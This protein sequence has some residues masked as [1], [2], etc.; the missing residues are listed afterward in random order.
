MGTKM[1]TKTGL[2][3]RAHSRIEFVMR[4]RFSARLRLDLIWTAATFR[5]GAAP[6]STACMAIGNETNADQQPANSKALFTTGLCQFQTL[7]VNG[8]NVL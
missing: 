4:A 2:W 1:G 3:G 8:P 6:T 7:R 5:C